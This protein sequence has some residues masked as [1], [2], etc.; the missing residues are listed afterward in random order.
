L[1]LCILEQ[2]P[3]KEEDYVQIAENIDGNYKID[4]TIPK[5][6]LTYAEKDN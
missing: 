2:N 5:E 4:I 3:S 1:N 6:Y